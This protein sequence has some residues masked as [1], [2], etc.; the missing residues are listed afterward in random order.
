[1]RVVVLRE[2]RVGIDGLGIGS[3]KLGVR[4]RGLRL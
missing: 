2:S 4:V 3:G 1:M